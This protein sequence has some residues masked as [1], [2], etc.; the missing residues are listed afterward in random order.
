MIDI[1]ILHN[2]IL[3]IWKHADEDRPE[4]IDARERLA[5]LKGKDSKISG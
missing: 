4:M 2:K 1:T 5:K 3:A